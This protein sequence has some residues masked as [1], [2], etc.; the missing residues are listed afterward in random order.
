MRQP[1]L[2]RLVLVVAVILALA[3][4]KGEC[5]V[6]KLKVPPG[7]IITS[8]SETHVHALITELRLKDY[9]ALTNIHAL[10]TVYYNGNGA[11]DEK[12]KAL[13]QLRF[14]NLA[15][16]VFTDCPL[17]TDEG[18]EHLS[19]IS[20]VNNLGLR[21]MTISDAACATMTARIRLHTVNM[22]KCTNVTVNGLLQMAR[23]KTIESLGFSVGKLGQNDLIQIISTA[24]PKLGR[25][26]IDMD[27]AQEERLDLPAL[28][29]AAEARKIKLFAVRNKSV[30]KF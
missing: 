22:P 24:G 15:C 3:A 7:V 27:G 25:I 21:H 8:E 14:T 2:I 12:L 6:A 30:T 16:V 13:A 4:V 28:R 10:F 9:P 11:T 23:S 29:R 17:V 20:T 5:A 1:L 19:T 18:I 26:D